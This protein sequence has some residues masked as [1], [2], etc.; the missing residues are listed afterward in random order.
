MEIGKVTETK[1]YVETDKK[2]NV[3][4]RTKQDVVR[5]KFMRTVGPKRRR[6]QYVERWVYYGPVVEI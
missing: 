6:E 4:R 3:V 1:E 5:T 2:G